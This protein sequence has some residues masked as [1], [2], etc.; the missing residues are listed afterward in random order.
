MRHA[1]LLLLSACT[2]LT[3]TWEGDCDYGADEVQVDLELVQEED[4]ISGEGTIGYLVGNQ[5]EVLEVEVDGKKDGDEIELELETAEAGT[6][7]ITAILEDKAT[8]VGECLWD[9]AGVFELKRAD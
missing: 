5:L 2:P 6:M 8:I 9:E 7:E 3:A 4:D 1:A